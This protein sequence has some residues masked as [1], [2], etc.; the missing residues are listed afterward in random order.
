MP[1]FA[2]GSVMEIRFGKEY[3]K[4]LYFKGKTTDKKHRLPSSI[5]SRYCRIIDI[6][7]SVSAVEDL[8]RY[9]SLNYKVLVG[10][11]NGLESVRVNDKYRIEFR[12]CKVVS[13]VVV[14]VCN[15]EELS[16]HYK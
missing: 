2:N 10:D 4:E 1:I 16:N 12:T 13:D 3:L 5:V 11:K 6:L 8:Y 15:I 7:E 14:T 9:N